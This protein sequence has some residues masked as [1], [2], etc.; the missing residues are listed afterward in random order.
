ML[1]FC[2]RSQTMLFIESAIIDVSWSTDS[3]MTNGHAASCS[4]QST[5]LIKFIVYLFST[6]LR[7]T[8]VECGPQKA[9]ATSIISPAIAQFQRTHTIFSSLIS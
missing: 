5:G 6:I 4:Q 8:H 9:Y 1:C 7:L 2:E 3:Q